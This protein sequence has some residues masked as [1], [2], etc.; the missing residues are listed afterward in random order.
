MNSEQTDSFINEQDDGSFCLALAPCTSRV[1]AYLLDPSA[2]IIWL[3][4]HWPHRTIQWWQAP[5]PLTTTDAARLLRVR[6]LSYDLEMDRDTFLSELPQFEE[7]GMDLYQLTRSV[8]DS[9]RVEHLT[10]KV[11]RRVLIQNGAVSHFQLPHAGEVA[12]FWAISRQ[13]LERALGYPEIRS[14]AIRNLNDPNPNN[15]AT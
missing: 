10:E 2:R 6:N 8:P 1:L 14:L 12:V 11:R 13:I 7:F 4:N 15:R 5:V 3:V 9:L